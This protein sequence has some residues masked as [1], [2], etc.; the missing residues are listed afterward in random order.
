MPKQKLYSTWF[1]ELDE[2]IRNK[3][4]ANA[5]NYG[6]NLK[7]EKDV[8]LSESLCGAFVW[9]KTPEGHMYWTK[10]VHNLRSQGK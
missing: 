6:T 7:K 9:N 3:V 2:D 4:L 10:I 5:I 8:S 1:K